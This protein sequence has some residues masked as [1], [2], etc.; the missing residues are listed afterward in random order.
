MHSHL[1]D[2]DNSARIG[3][4]FFLNV[5]F[6]IVEFIGGILTNSTAIM[7][8]AIHDLGD[9]LSIGLAWVLAK[10][11]NRPASQ[12]FS[13]GY[14]RLSLL[15]SLINGIV[16]IAGSAWVLYQYSPSMVCFSV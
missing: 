1:H 2:E 7:A 16:L 15:G 10:L 12:S 14:K 5:G 9:S 6:T 3:W 8:D 13:Y 4:A 11:G